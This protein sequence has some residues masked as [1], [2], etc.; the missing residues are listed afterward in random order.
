MK[1]N[2]EFDKT[3]LGIRLKKEIRGLNEEIALILYQSALVEYLNEY[4]ES[5]DA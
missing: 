1:D 4:E 3:P 5:Q 2:K